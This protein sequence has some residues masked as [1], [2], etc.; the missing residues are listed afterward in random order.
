MV[1]TIIDAV[2]VFI[3][4][5]CAALLLYGGWLYLRYGS[6]RKDAADDQQP[7]AHALRQNASRC[8]RMWRESLVVLVALLAA[9]GSTGAIAATI[10]E[11]GMHEYEQGD[12]VRA[13]TKFRSAAEKGDPRAQE[14]LGLMYAFGPQLYPGVAQDLRAAGLWLDRAA[15]SGRPAARFAY[16]A[17]IRKERPERAQGWRC[18]DW[19]VETGSPR[20]QPGNIGSRR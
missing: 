6:S 11:E 13:H 5:T 19:I 7:F 2:C 16:C 14:L 20:P 17:L 4:A 3:F 9:V 12:Y 8:V 10:F 1:A 18:F 15:R